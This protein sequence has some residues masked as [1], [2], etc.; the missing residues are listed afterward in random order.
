MSALRQFLEFCISQRWID[1]SI[2]ACC[3]SMPDSA[4]RREWLH[5]EQVVAISDFVDTTELLDD[6][7][8]FAFDVLRDLGIRSAET[9]LRTSSLDPRTK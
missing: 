7:D 8:R 4:P 5:P 2:L 1:A 6:W 9:T 3:V